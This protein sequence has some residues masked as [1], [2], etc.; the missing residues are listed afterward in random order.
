MNMGFSLQDIEL[1][2]QNAFSPLVGGKSFLGIDIGSSS[3]KAVQLRHD[4][5]VPVLETFGEI[6]LAPY[7]DADR[8]RPAAIEP[9]K[10]SAAILD[11]IHEIDATTRIGAIAVPLPSALISVIDLPKRDEEQMRRIIR[12]EVQKY[13]PI[14]VDKVTLEWFPI[15]D[16]ELTRD[17]LD[18]AASGAPVQV[19]LQ[20]IFLAAIDN[21]IL[22]RYAQI[23]QI[24]ELDMRFY[25]IESFGFIR[26]T[27]AT[28]EGPALLID[29]GTSTS[30]ICI[31]SRRHFL[32]AAHSVLLGG[33]HMSD[34]IARALLWNFPQAELAK[35]TRGLLGAAN[36]TPEENGKITGAIKKVLD[37]ILAEAI[38][39]R[40]AYNA[41]YK[42]PITHVILG[43]GGAKLAGIVDYTSQKLGIETRVA[44]PFEKVKGPMVLEDALHEAGPKYAAA[45]GI[46]LRGREDAEK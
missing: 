22:K 12:G 18:Q 29:I 10:I 37:S 41:E 14:S 21:E 46:A 39:L 8:G 25:E 31:A 35:I 13:I 11:L 45:L 38:R 33:Q 15:P 40:D 6:D 26:S 32:R 16:D 43:G 23:S 19:K 42:E 24:S 1:R 30:K 3:I 4:G 17:A 27:A 2:V 7:A 34:E 5:S 36:Y 20:K 44:R 28:S 9:Q